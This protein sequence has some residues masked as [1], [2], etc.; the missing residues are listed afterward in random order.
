MIQLSLNHSSHVGQFLA[1]SWKI[2][3][4][5]ILSFFLYFYFYDGINILFIFFFTLKN[6]L[7]SSLTS[8]DIIYNV[9]CSYLNIYNFSFYEELMCKIKGGV[10]C[11]LPC[12][13]KRD[14]LIS[15]FELQCARAWVSCKN[16]YTYNVKY[17]YLYNLLHVF[18][19]CS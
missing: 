1:N 5:L 15:W 10:N 2:T 8:N 12:V 3:H 9:H 4:T 18:Y 14:W 13:Q 11:I 19:F 16:Q 7:Q 17:M 6:H